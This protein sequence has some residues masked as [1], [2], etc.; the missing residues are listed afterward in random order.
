MRNAFSVYR[1]GEKSEG[2]SLRH[3]PEDTVKSKLRQGLARKAVS[4]GRER[5]QQHL[6]LGC[7]YTLLHLHVYLCWLFFLLFVF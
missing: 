5:F 4:V 2:K 6:E 1:H 3:L 7:Y